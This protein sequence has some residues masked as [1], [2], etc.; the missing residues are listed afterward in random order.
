M[1]DVM[2]RS[3]FSIKHEIDEGTINFNLKIYESFS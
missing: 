1:Y 3:L 2:Y